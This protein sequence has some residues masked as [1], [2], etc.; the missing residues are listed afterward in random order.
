MAKR[1]R[2]ATLADIDYAIRPYTNTAISTLSNNN[3]R[4]QPAAYWRQIVAWVLIE[5]GAGYRETAVAIRRDK[6]T[7][8]NARAKIN[9]LREE[10][11]EVRRLTDRLVQRA[12]EKHAE[13]TTAKVRKGTVATE[14]GESGAIQ[15]CSP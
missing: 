15:P 11:P 3:T 9:H 13:R 4:H 6:P 7:V 1:E 2:Q 14:E 8:E 10:D 12:R 5:T